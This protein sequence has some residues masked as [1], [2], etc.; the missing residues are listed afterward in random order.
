[1]RTLDLALLGFGNAGRAFAR[2]LTEK[3]DAVMAQ[4]GA[5]LRVTAIATGHH[6]SLIRPEGVVLRRAVEFIESGGCFYRDDD[7]LTIAQSAPYDILVEA[8][9]LNTSRR[10]SVRNHS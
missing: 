1:M 6:G 2:L 3:H 8:T 9:P 5:D 4:Y 10:P 7:A